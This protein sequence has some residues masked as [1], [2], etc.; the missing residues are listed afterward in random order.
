MKI[1]FIT[2]EGYTLPGARVRCYNFSRELSRYGIGTEVL[3][4]SDT[5]GA[6]DG[7]KESRMG[8]RDKIRFNYLA[9]KKL[10]SQK[11]A[12][13][14]L[15]RFNYHSFAP[16]L[17][18]ML[19]G[20]RLILDLDD[21]EMRENPKYCFFYP[22]SKAHYFTRA[23]AKRSIFCVAASNFLKDFLLQFNSKVYCIPSG[24]DTALFN[25]SLNNVSG[26]EIIFS[27]IG[28]FHKNEYV[29]NITFALECFSLL[30]KKY[31]HIYFDIVGD[32]IHKNTLITVVDK[33]GDPQIRMKSWIP[34]DQIPAYLSNIHIGLFPV[35]RD[36]KFNKA[37][38]PTK[39]FEYMAMGKPTISSDIGEPRYIINDGENGFLADT[40][41]KF[42][43]SMHR[44]VEDSNLR[45]IMGL[46]ARESIEKSYSLDIMG[47]RL[48]DALMIM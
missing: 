33:F 8:I 11:D 35:A 19:K 28:T 29:E 39:L 27:W 14:Y 32:G 25:P 31:E 24:V 26:K 22:I 3:S 38:S 44:L 20:N 42:A 16:Y 34:P 2:R 7:E 13:L 41:E 15:Q 10:S 23:I 12:I 43:E 17:V 9:F 45:K 6:E 36:T 47:K 21:W 4:F 40:K 1:I 5:L 30:R 18:H 37:K 46:K 48:F